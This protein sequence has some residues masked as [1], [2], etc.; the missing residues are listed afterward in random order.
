MI[1]FLTKPRGDRRWDRFLRATGVLALLGIPTI[2]FLPRLIPLVW[3]AVLAIPA[4]SPLS[5][6]LPTAFEPLMMEA[7]KYERAIW[8]TLVALG[9]YL[10]MEYL[11]WHLYAWV[12][13]RRMSATFKEKPWVRWTVNHFARAPSATVMFVAFTPVPFWAVRIVAILGRYPLRPFL[14]ATAIG[15]FPRFFLYAWLGAWLRVPTVVLLAVIFG[16]AAAVVIYRLARG[17]PVLEDTV[18]EH[19]DVPKQMSELEDASVGSLL[20]PQP[21]TG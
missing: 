2:V 19:I 1:A 8:V 20:R 21:P 11:N 5:P 9:T 12:L 14:V 13:D 15:R 4:N 10:Y 18:T 17:K 6:I 3:L 16:T 7:A